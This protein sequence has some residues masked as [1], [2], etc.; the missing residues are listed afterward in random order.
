MQPKY[1]VVLLFSYNDIAKTL[2]FLFVDQIQL[3]TGGNEESQDF[4]KFTYAKVRQWTKICTLHI[5]TTMSV[6]IWK[7]TK[8]LCDSGNHA[9]LSSRLLCTL[10]EGYVQVH[11]GSVL[12]P[13]TTSSV[14]SRLDIGS[15]RWIPNCLSWCVFKKKSYKLSFS[16]RKRK[17]KLLLVNWIILIWLNNFL[18]HCWYIYL[19]LLLMHVVSLNELC[20]HLFSVDTWSFR[21]TVT[22]R[23]IAANL[24]ALSSQL[25]PTCQHCHFECRGN[26]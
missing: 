2:L 16:D 21:L 3:L 11:V 20:I 6:L 5:V 12:F 23:T 22:H 15:G 14:R 24:T 18:V 19:V 4:F 17:E 7:D 10:L 1:A 13:L 25:R 26:R 8:T 9:S